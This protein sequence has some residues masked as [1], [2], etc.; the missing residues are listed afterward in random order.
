MKTLAYRWFTGRD[1]VGIVLC[2]D[3]ITK[4]KK[5]YIGGVVGLNEADDIE[6]IKDWGTSFPV[7]V[8]E[9]LF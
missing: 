7:N 9:K 5:A 4:E 6:Y 3:E 2:E 1:C 8:A